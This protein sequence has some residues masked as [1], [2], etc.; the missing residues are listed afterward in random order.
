MKLAIKFGL[1][2]GLVSSL[3]T[4]IGF[5]QGFNQESLGGLAGVLPFI[6]LY[7]G[8][9]TGIYFQRKSDEFGPGIL[10]FKEAARTGVIISLVAGICLAGY[11]MLSGLVINPSYLEDYMALVREVLEKQSTP[12]DEIERELADIKSSFTVG[13]LM[14]SKFMIT[15]LIG[16]AGAFIMAG[17]LKNDPDKA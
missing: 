17:L 15:L 14:F 4:F 7:I 8:I 2:A 16:M 10:S 9:A 6:I 5:L 3:W 12:I 11:S 13:Q 1:I